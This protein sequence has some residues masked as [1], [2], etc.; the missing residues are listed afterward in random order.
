[1]TC[2]ASEWP[3]MARYVNYDQVY[4]SIIDYDQLWQGIAGIAKYITY[5]KYLQAW[6]YMASHCPVWSIMTNCGQLYPIMCKYF[7]V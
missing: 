4:A 7:Q 6:P 5:V 2:Y 1:M 3:I